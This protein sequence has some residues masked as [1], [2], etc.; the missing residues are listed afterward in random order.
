MHAASPL[1]WLLAHVGSVFVPALELIARIWHALGAGVWEL[2]QI[3]AFAASHAH[4]LIAAVAILVLGG[5]CLACI[6]GW[7]S[8]SEYILDTKIPPSNWK[9][10]AALAVFCCSVCAL[11]SGVRQ[12]YALAP[13]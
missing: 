2:W 11:D 4:Q 13:L 8:S 1:P 6:C 7:L 10:L 9:S 12:F 5:F 3:G